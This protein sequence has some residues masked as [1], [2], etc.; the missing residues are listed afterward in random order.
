VSQPEQ[1]ELAAELR[2]RG[3]VDQDARAFAVRGDGATE[4]EI[5]H[6]MR[7]DRDN[8]EWLETVV[9]E[10]GW[11]GLRLVGAEGAHAAWLLAQ[12]ADE[13]PDLQRHWLQL[14]Q[15][16][17]GTGDA[18]P[19]NVAYLHDRLA[20]ADRRPQRHGTQWIKLGE[21]ISLAP[22]EDPQRVN[23]YRTAAGLDPLGD[24]EIAAA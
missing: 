13:R 17:A 14:L 4:T 16:A 21:R 8:T 18:E 7:V 3:D 20:T 15:A 2:R 11:P 12:H 23:A 24:D 22:L 5:Q 10:H 9:A 19:R 1:P 6:V